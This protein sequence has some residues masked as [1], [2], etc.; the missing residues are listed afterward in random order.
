MSTK[1]VFITGGV[2]SGIG[3]G[4]TISS[5]ARLLKSRG[6]KIFM[7][8][9]DPYVNVDPG[10]MSPYQHG[11]VYVTGDGMEADLDLGHYERFID[12]NLTKN[13]NIT[14]GQIYKNVI[15]KERKGMYLGSTVQVI[16]HITNEIKKKI[17]DAAEDSGADIVITEI[18][19]TVGDIES[20]P[21]IEAIRQV[22]LKHNCVYIHTTLV[23]YLDASREYKSKPTQHSVTTLRSLGI[24]PDIIVAR[25]TGHIGD[26]IKK[27]IA[28]FS[29]LSDEEVFNV[30][31]V[32]TIFEVPLLLHEQKMDEIIL[33]KLDLNAK[34]IDLSEWISLNEKVNNLNKS[35]SI[36]LV[37]KYVEFH[38]AYLSVK[39]ALKAAGFEFGTNVEIK[40]VQAKDL[41]SDNVEQVL[42]N[43]QGIL[44]PGGFGKKGIE[45]K[46]VA[47]KYARENNIPFLGICLGMQLA[48]VEFAR[49][50]LKIP[51]ASSSEW[52]TQSNNYV[53]DIIDNISKEKLGGT[54]RLGNYN[55]E[56]KV[57]S[58]AHRLYKESAIIERHRHR[59]EF[60]NLYRDK[61]EKKG[62]VFSGINSKDEL[63]EI[64]EYPKNDYFIATQFHPEFTSRPTK[65]HSLFVG[66]VEHSLKRVKF[67]KQ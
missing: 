66:F 65:P 60:N 53:I 12:E 47:I 46:I 23:P 7:Q 29:I 24:T 9:F 64:I 55:C 18:G 33:N 8:K 13:S 21:F 34:N 36:A 16:P 15:E 62:F 49:N 35:V 54:L 61:F 42:G 43:V 58:L 37:G 1:F 11:E 48:C 2:V 32:K 28:L 45:G 22:S 57:G 17:F 40:W 25:S 3:K 5:L 14:T 4:I 41:T 51:D 56:L 67:C 38:D 59:Y 20:L 63:V 26:D 6:Y 52:E 39:E 27:K 19:G 50:I 31:D 30:V 44:V 10:T